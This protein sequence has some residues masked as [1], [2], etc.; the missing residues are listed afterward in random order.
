MHKPAWT[1]AQAPAAK[2]N[3][4]PGFVGLPVRLHPGDDL[5]LALEHV[6]A[7]QG[8]QAGFVVAGIGSLR[9]ALVRLAAGQE[10]LRLDEDVE[11]LSLSGSLCP[12]GS[13]LHLCVSLRDGR[14]LGGHAAYGCVVR[15]TAEVLLAPLPAWQ[16]CRELDIGTGYDELVIRKATA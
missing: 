8:V 9:P 16:F 13:H 14:V 11:L 15:T 5:R 10:P 1:G 12:T 6:I 3:L 2:P 4:A 7:R